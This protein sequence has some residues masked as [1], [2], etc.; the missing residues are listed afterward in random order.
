MNIFSKI[1]GLISKIYPVKRKQS[2]KEAR[3]TATSKDYRYLSN[4]SFRSQEK[5][6]PRQRLM[7][8][9]KDHRNTNHPPFGM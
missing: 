1:I 9:L 5:T 3:T 7:R 4:I 6:P 2:T 8:Q